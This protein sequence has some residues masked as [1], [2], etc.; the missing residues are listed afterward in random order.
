[1]MMMFGGAAKKLQQQSLRSLTV[2]QPTFGFARYFNK[3]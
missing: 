2:Q 1:M 3:A